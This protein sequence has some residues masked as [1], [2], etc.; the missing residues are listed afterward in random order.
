[1]RFLSFGYFGFEALLNHFSKGLALFGARALCRA[2]QRFFD[3][4]REVDKFLLF[5]AHWRHSYEITYQHVNTFSEIFSDFSPILPNPLILKRIELSIFVAPHPISGYRRNMMKPI[6][7]A[8]H[9]QTGK[10]HSDAFT[11]KQEAQRFFAELNRQE[12]RDSS[13]VRWQLATVHPE[14]AAGFNIN[15]Y[16]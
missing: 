2:V 4:H 8:V 16:E 5:T 15:P 12:K 11:S 3:L 13:R 9:S 7:T 14:L 1:M 10:A 6:Y